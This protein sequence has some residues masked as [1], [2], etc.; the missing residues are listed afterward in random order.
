[1][2]TIATTDGTQIYYKDWGSGQPVVFSY[3]WPLSADAFEDQMVFL[4]SNGYRCIAHDRRG[5]GRSS[6]PWNGYF[7]TVRALTAHVASAEERCRTRA[8]S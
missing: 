4:A 5:H 3:G 8:T 2:P 1:M 6:Q 7:K